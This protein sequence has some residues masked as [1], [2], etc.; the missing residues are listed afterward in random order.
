[1]KHW[2]S[3]TLLQGATK[4]LDGLLPDLPGLRKQLDAQLAPPLRDLDAQLQ[5]AAQEAVYAA[6]AASQGL[7]HGLGGALQSINKV[8]IGGQWQVR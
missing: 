1:M 3:V 7:V 2:P 6:T 5:A 4:Q 8:L